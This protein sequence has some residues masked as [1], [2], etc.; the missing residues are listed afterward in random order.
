MARLQ[1]EFSQDFDIMVI[2]TNELKLATLYELQTLYSVQD[3]YD[4]L[5]IMDAHLAMVE[6]NRKVAEANAPKG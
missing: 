5:E 1:E 6:H 3:M 4:L 2:V